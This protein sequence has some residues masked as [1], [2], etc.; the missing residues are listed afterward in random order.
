MNEY[1]GFVNSNSLNCKP[2][3]NY[4]KIYPLRGL[5][6]SYIIHNHIK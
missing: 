5:P 4:A 6:L 1:Y 2:I 3:Y